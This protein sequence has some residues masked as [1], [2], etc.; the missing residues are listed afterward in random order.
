MNSIL[1]TSDHRMSGMVVDG[2]GGVGKGNNWMVAWNELAR[3]SMK[4]GKRSSLTV[5]ESKARRLAMLEFSK[6]DEAMWKQKLRE[7]WLKEGD[8]RVLRAFPNLQMRIGDPTLMGWPL[9]WRKGFKVR[10]FHYGV[11]EDE[12]S[13]N[14]VRFFLELQEFEAER[15]SFLLFICFGNGGTK[16]GRGEEG[17]SS[18]DSKWTL[19][20]RGEGRME[21]SHLLFLDNTLILFYANQQHLEYLNWV[22][23]WFELIS[24]L[25]RK[26]ALWKGQYLS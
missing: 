2:I 19:G 24:S 13:T 11:L 15:P 4:M 25:K 6:W 3:E 12:L 9:K 18:R 17:I 23:I 14:F 16:F 22:F 5:E 8:K 21:V 7:I 1:K 26:L 20:G 10:W